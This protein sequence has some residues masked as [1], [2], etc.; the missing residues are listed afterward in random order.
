MELRVTAGERV[1][2]ALTAESCGTVL[3]SHLPFKAGIR[4]EDF[5]NRF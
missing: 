2:S 1:L 3:S 4:F 5:T